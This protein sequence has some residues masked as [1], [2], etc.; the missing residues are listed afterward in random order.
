[1]TIE[2]IAPESISVGQTLEYTLVIKNNGGAVANVRVEDELPTNVKLV[3]CEPAAEQ[4]DHR[5]VWNLGTLESAGERRIRIFVK[6][7]DEG[8]LRSRA[9]VTFS[10]AAE[11]R[12]KVTR[13]RIAV[14]LAGMETAR[15]GDE[16]PFQI[17]VTNTGSGPA[18]NLLVKAK[19]SDGLHH[20]AGGQIEAM[21]DRLPAG[22]TKTITL[23]ALATKAGSNGCSIS[24]GSE[25]MNAEVAN[26]NVAIVEP[27]L[28]TK[29]HGPAKC[30]VRSEPEFRIELNNPGS[31]S[32]DPVQV[33][34][35]LPDGFDFV[36]ASDSGVY[37]AANRL[38]VWQMPGLAMNTA[39]TLYLKL[40]AGG[41]TEGVLKVVAQSA[42]PAETGVVTAGAK[43]NPARVIEVKAEAAVKAEGMPALRFEVADVEDPV[44]VGK[45]AVYD[46]K[47][48]NQGTASCTNVVVTATLAEGTVAAGATGPCTARGTGQVITFDALPQLAAKGEAVYRVKVRGTA[49]GDLKI[50]VGVSCDEIRTPTTREENTRFFKD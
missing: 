38:V 49:A 23:R 3:R 9:M 27:M 1:M 39:R 43:G 26:S 8:E 36:S 32:T 5:L 30:L 4:T 28:T 45:E 7:S 40:K 42:P 22:E 33:W 21:I 16:V 46:I 25:G 29:L 48:V 50:K 24:A 10:G 13:P 14:S 2:C 18:T 15:V 20:P 31:A 6:P 34:A 11:A 37:Q 44:E 47:V 41:A 19:L 35:V 17:K 12:V